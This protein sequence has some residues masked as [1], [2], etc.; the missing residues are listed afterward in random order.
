MLGWLIPASRSFA[1]ADSLGAAY[2][3]VGSFADA[4]C[5]ATGVAARSGVFAGHV[6]TCGK[7]E[8]AFAI[9]RV[10]PTNVRNLMG[11][12]GSGHIRFFLTS[13]NESDHADQTRPD[14][15]E[16]NLTREKLWL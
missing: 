15:R 3:A 7:G 6:P 11:R 9:S 1:R 14:P 5:R 10:G 8:E 2:F 13:R 12:V 16:V 4:R